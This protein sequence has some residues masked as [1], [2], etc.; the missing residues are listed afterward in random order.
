MMVTLE[1]VSH[2]SRPGKYLNQISAFPRRRRAK[3][4]IK[5][6][7]SC[8]FSQ[9]DPLSLGIDVQNQLSAALQM[10]LPSRPPLRIP[11]HTEKKSVNFGFD[12][13]ASQGGRLLVLREGVCGCDVDEVLVVELVVFPEEVHVC[14]DFG[15]SC[16][17]HGEADVRGQ[18]G[19]IAGI[20]QN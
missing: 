3:N 4:L 1:S 19:L 13:V 2:V 12:S 10:P 18:C 8:L 5:K 20:V 7:L 15:G 17:F 14:R 9:D 6:F 11:A 16:S